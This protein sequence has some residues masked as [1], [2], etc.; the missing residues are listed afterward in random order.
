MQRACTCEP[1]VKDS[2]WIMARM[3][4]KSHLQY[5]QII[6]PIVSSIPEHTNITADDAPVF[7]CLDIHHQT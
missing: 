2:D 4:R 3:A 6:S 1:D 5:E 7:A